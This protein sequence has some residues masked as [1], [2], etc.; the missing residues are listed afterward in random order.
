M[1]FALTKSVLAALVIEALVIAALIAV[2]ANKPAK[3][4]SP[5][6]VVMLTFPA[7]VDKP[8]A[9]P[10]KEPP[11]PKVVQHKAPPKPREEK[12]IVPEP[13]I[14]EAKPAEPAAPVTVPVKPVVQAKPAPAA[15]VSDSFKGA[16]RAAVQAAVVY[17]PS[18]RMAHIVGKTKV[19]FRYQDGRVDNSSVVTSSGFNTLD[20]AAIR[21]VEAAAY[22]APPAEFAGKPLQFEVWVRFFLSES[23]DD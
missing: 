13:K 2:V 12:E 18:A 3:A 19:A 6:P 11:P 14:A 7:P 16:V 20:A 23:I 9:P 10:K 17:P 8:V 1:K 15:T 21:A 5:E 22:P 4:Q